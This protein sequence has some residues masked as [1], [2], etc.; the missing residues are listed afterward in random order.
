MYDHTYGNGV[1]GEVE[2]KKLRKNT[3]HVTIEEYENT[4]GETTSQA[5]GVN[6]KEK[7]INYLIE[8]IVF[9]LLS[10]TGQ[11]VLF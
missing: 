8:S 5:N 3:F 4:S 2:T 6:S 1:V 9:L 11:I 7:V 10:N